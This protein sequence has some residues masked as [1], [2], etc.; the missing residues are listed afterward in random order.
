[1][2]EGGR[3]PLTP[4][5]LIGRASGWPTARRYMHSVYREER[6]I[7]PDIG[8]TGIQAR[9]GRTDLGRDLRVCSGREDGAVLIG[10]GATATTD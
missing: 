9:E 8:L 3:S 5:G 10:W 4:L 2:K 1:M 6:P 7:S